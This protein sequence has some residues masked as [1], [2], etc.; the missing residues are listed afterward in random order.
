MQSKSSQICDDSYLLANLN[1]ARTVFWP[2]VRKLDLGN[3]NYYLIVEDL[4][5]A[6]NLS[7]LEHLDL[8]EVNL[9]GTKYDRSL[10]KVLGKLPRLLVLKLSLTELDNTNLPH[11]C[12]NF[13]L[14]SKVQYLDLSANSFGGEFPCFLRNMAS[15]KFLDLSYNKYN[16]FDHNPRFLLPNNIAH[17]DLDSNNLYHDTDWI[18]NFMW[19][20]CHLRSLQLGGNQLHGDLS[21]VVGNLSGCWINKLENLNLRQNRIYGHIPTS[22][23]KL[24]ALVSF[25][26][27]YNRL[28]GPILTSIESLRALREL[29]LNANQLSGDIPISLGKLPNLETINISSNRFNGSLS[30]AHFANLTRLNSISMS[31]LELR[32]AYDWVPPFFQLQT[33][34]IRSCNIGGRFPE[35][36]RSQKALSWLV[37]SNS[38]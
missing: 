34:V 28:S 14:L 2:S 17:V 38:S 11:D 19:D 12:L 1:V 18:S 32:L 3:N 33:L 36:I 26:V 20:K 13:T 27:S 25:D 22:L 15:L 4:S 29:R 21:R 24:S 31:M 7:F 5:W 8:S 6:S 37:L 9:S 10:V 35:W 16:S 30:E 23:G